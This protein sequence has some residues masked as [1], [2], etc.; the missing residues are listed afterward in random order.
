M[1][2]TE[3]SVVAS[4]NEIRR[5]ER[6]R[7]TRETAERRRVE[8]ESAERHIGDDGRRSSQGRPVAGPRDSGAV[9][10]WAHDPY[11]AYGGLRR[12]AEILPISD[13]LPAGAA[14]FGASLVEA[15]RPSS[16]RAVLLT[17][18]VLAGAA[19]GGYHQLDKQ[20]TER[21]AMAEA[22]RTAAERERNEAFE[23]RARAERAAEQQQATLMQRVQ[24]AEAASA[25]A[26]ARVSESATTDGAFP[27]A[28]AESATK[29]AVKVAA[30]RQPARAERTAPRQEAAVALP[31][32][33]KKKSVSDNPIGGLEL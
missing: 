33:V 14:P 22:G 12:T 26:L 32:P 8:R 1:A 20:W 7:T 30:K 21:L 28:P 16:L 29:I 23:A 4:L 19:A 13:G 25:A 6:E 31:K 17:T 2:I 18:L 15:R 24:A 9:Q 3:N 10:T 11:A 27:P 5:I